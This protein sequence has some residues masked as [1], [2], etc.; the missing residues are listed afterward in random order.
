MEAEVSLRS[1][2]ETQAGD[3]PNE[4]CEDRSHPASKNSHSAMMV[5]TK[6]ATDRPTR[7]V[8]TRTRKPGITIATGSM[9][10]R[11]DFL[12]GGTTMPDATDESKELR[13]KGRRTRASDDLCAEIS[14][15][16]D[17]ASHFE[18]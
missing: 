9:G 11:N 12:S 5:I 4:S 17:A 7:A 1:P 8:T 3:Y 16:F 13:E 10:R 14:R 2:P 15:P 6:A 18:N